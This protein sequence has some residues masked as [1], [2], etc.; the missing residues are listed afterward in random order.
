M[1][2]HETKKRVKGLALWV[3]PV[4]P[5]ENLVNKCELTGNAMKIWFAK[6]LSGFKIS[7]K[8]IADLADAELSHSAGF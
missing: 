4:T 8:S 6:H 2:P 5:P 3:R 1:E 7:F